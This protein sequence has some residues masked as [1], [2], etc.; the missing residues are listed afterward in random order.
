[1]AYGRKLVITDVHPDNKPKQKMTIELMGGSPWFGYI[2]LNGACYTVTE[3]T[4]TIQ[5]KKTR[6]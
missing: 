3:G 4:R 6:L 5:I 1:M 2:W